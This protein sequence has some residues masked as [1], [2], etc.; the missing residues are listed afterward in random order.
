MYFDPP[1]CIVILISIV[2]SHIPWDWYDGGGT[3]DVAGA[4]FPPPPPTTVKAG[5]G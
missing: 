4:V 5:G 3:D 2:Y 1:E